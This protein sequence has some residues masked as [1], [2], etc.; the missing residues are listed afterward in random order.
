MKLSKK[1]ER[2]L[3]S[4]LHHLERAEKY[5]KG[6]RIAGVA[7]ETDNPNGASYHIENTECSEVHTVDVVTTFTGSDLMGLPMAR[8]A[9]AEFLDGKP[10]KEEED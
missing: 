1:Q 2:T 8:Q 7:W 3:R 5:L 6:G 9:L 4:I 10:E